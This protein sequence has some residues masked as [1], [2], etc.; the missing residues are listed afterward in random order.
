MTNKT[1]ISLEEVVQ[2][3]ELVREDLEVVEFRATIIRLALMN[4]I[5][6]FNRWSVHR[7]IKII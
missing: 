5:K 6:P 7:I 2:D 4:S 3:P 1:L